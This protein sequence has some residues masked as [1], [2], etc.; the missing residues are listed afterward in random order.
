MTST[1]RK[2]VHK[3]GAQAPMERPK[4]TLPEAEAEAVRCAYGAASVILEYGSGGSTVLGAEMPGKRIFS[5]ESDK[6]WL[7]MMERWFAANPPL[8]RLSLHH[9][10]IGPTKD[11]GAPV[12][13]AQFRRWPSYPLSVWDRADFEHPDVVLI[14][15]RFRAAC[16]LTALFRITRPVTVLWD[17]YTERVGYHVMESF[18]PLVRTHGRMA[19]FH[20]EPG[21]VPT[22][23]LGLIL[24][25]YLRPN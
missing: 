4:L 6:R 14:D 24:T 22:E 17:D 2:P 13:D 16:F 7:G 5:V 18:A 3:P 8:S 10:D 20:L 12:D 11:W 21:P 25:T 15:G 19:E 9:G 1:A 23:R